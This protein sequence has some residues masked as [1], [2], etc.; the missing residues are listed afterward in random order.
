MKNKSVLILFGWAL[1]MS[2]FYCFSELLELEDQQLSK[3]RGQ[4]AVG[5]E[6][7]KV[8][9]PNHSRSANN[10]VVSLPDTTKSFSAGITMDINLQMHIDEIR[11]V[12]SDGAGANGQQGAIRL[13]GFSMGN[14]GDNTPAAIRGVTVDVDGK[15]G[16]VLGVQQI[17]GPNTGIDVNIESIQF[18]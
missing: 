12:D 18:R 1:L 4:T 7:Q 2:P 9:L 15:D 6:A 17:G 11:W 8:E 14:L 13:K 10:D 5:I 3:Y 16:L